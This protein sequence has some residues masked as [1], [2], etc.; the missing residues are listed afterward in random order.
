MHLTMSD[1]LLI[2]YRSRVDSLTLTLKEQI[3]GAYFSG[4][5]VARLAL[6]FKM[7]RQNVYHHLGELTSVEKKIHKENKNKY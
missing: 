2:D 1:D 3:R 7:T 6:A 5:P 4:V